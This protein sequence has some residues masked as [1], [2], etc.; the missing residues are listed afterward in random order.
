[1]TCQIIMNL[2]ICT[3]G[4]LHHSDLFSTVKLTVAVLG[5]SCFVVL[6]QS[7]MS[8]LAQPCPLLAKNIKQDASLT[9]DVSHF[10]P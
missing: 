7:G 1:M 2:P 5:E 3:G 6:I 8:F 4:S 10:N 9:C